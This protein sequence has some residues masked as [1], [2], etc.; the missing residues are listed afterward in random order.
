MKSHQCV[1]GIYYHP[2]TQW[3]FSLEGFYKTHNHLLNDYNGVD[4]PWSIQIGK[5]TFIQE[6]DIPMGWNGWGKEEEQMDG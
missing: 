1:L 3:H 2:C 5:K 6:K 4:V